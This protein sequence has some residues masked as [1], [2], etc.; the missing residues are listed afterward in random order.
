MKT[1]KQLFCL[2]PVISNP[3]VR[4]LQVYKNNPFIASDCYFLAYWK[5]REYFDFRGR[6]IKL[7]GIIEND[8]LILGNSVLQNYL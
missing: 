7:I 5:Q 3:Y 4:I 6:C 2:N 1:Q 8:G